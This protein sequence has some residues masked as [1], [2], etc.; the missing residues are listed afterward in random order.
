MTTLDVL[1]FGPADKLTG[2][3]LNDKWM[4]A[5]RLARDSGDDAAS[6]C[7]CYRAM[8]VGTGRP[9]FVKA[10][11][12]KHDELAGDTERL[13]RL[14]SEF[15]NEKRVHEHC[16]TR[17][18]SRVTQI[19]DHGVVM[20]DGEP[21][22][23]I[24][25]EYADKSLR[26]FHPPGQAEVPAWERLVALRQT[27]SALVQLHGVGVA[28]QDVKPSNA[29]YFDDGR[30]KIT[31]LG[32]SSCIHLPAPP[33]DEDPYA[34]QLSYAPYELLYEKATNSNFAWQR[35]R[36]GCDV[37]LLGNLIFTSFVGGSLTAL[38]L[39]DVADELKPGRFTG[40]YREI[41]PDLLAA[42][43]LIIDPFIAEVAPKSIA[44]KLASLVSSL[45]HPDPLQRGL[46]NCNSLGERA[47]EMHRAVSM[48]DYLALKAKRDER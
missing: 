27:A 39:H 4:I 37:F 23:Y 25:C 13:E 2:R 31:D 11:D 17:R 20:V 9:A 26:N 10:Y 12:F 29:V 8:A 48:L 19:F 46:G 5:D 3:L 42:H 36:Y 22:H 33:H 30:I 7:A 18:L 43:A 16:K 28:H 15:N 41:M 35:R 47:Y 24:V 6:R 32:S 38:I 34:G 40:P 1:Q 44:S 45:C 21:V 14:L